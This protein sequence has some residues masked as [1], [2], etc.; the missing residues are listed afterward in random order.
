[1]KLIKNKKIAYKRM[2]AACMASVVFTMNI[3]L[4]V[5][6]AAPIVQVDETM[7]VNLDYYGKE[8]QANVVKGCTTNGLTSYT[9]F[10]TYDKVVNMTDKTEPVMEN[11]TLFWQLP[12]ENKRFY[13]QCTMPEGTTELPW[14]FDLSYKLNGVDMD[15]S[16]LAGA[17]GLVEINV[18]AVPNIKARAY[19]KNNMLLS[20]IVP[21]DMETC[22]SVEAPGSQLQSVGSSTIAAF[23]ALPGEEGDYTVRIGTDKFESSGVIMMMVPGTV[24]ALN[25]I[26]DLKEAKDTWRDD[27]NQMYNGV[28]EL[29]YA[30]ESMK[31]DVNQVK[32]GL[33]SLEEARSKVS[34]NRKQIEQLST[35][36]LADFKLVTEQTASVIPYLETAQSAVLDINDNV[37]AIYNTLEGTQ[38]ELDSLYDKL[39]NLRS[40]L[41]STSQLIG[42]GI[43]VE[44][45][46]AIAI[47]L[48]KQTAEIARLL[49][50]LEQL[51][52]EGGSTGDLTEEELL[53]LKSSLENADGFRYGRVSR[54]HKA[55]ASEAD[56][57]ADDLDLSHTGPSGLPGSGGLNDEDFEIWSDEDLGEYADDTEESLQS[58]MG[59]AYQNSVED[60]LQHIGGIVLNGEE[61]QKNAGAVIQRVNGLCASIGSTGHQTA[62]TLSSLRRVTDELVN[63]MDDSRVLIDTMDSYVPSMADSLGATEEL[64]NRLTKAMG[65]THTMLS[66]ISDTLTGAGDS[67]D[68]GTKDS[69]NGMMALLNKSLQTLDA[70][71]AIRVAGESM[72]GTV[73][74]QLDKFE[75]ENSF[76]NIDPEANM[77]SFTSAKNPS[78]H[79]LQ[80][81]VRSDEINEDD[82]A[83][84]A[85]DM[86]GGAQDEVSPFTRMWQV[87]VKIIESI[88][89]IF[90]NR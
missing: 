41:E 32:G 35:A 38:D 47:E 74:E 90:R 57:I 88:V 12:S 4:P 36:A 50:A 82:A 79:S 48:Q 76:L 84:E 75:E 6:A 34:G 16:N 62:Q 55:T 42:Q 21:V 80:I 58:L 23:A 43:T 46:Q 19:F 3:C 83:V 1:M 8:T 63:L 85:V 64:M 59:T 2:I 33:G 49:A 73:D 15:A 51:L 60:L 28:N 78:P 5:K 14:T 69:L 71:T 87:I 31:T 17:K 53:K 81:I 22:Y 30:M 25:Q 72:K 13:Y 27:G 66:L 44:E 40:S 9:D 29:L 65:S 70:V 26:K 39:G 77:L 37:N 61:V 7:Y 89:D 67:L 10:G 86:E 52:N 68:A 56:A 20:V 18:K 24:S 45:Q 54:S 11:G